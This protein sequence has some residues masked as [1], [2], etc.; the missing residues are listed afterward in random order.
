MNGSIHAEEHNMPQVV[1]KLF[2]DEFC[3]RIGCREATAV[4]SGTSALVGALLSL[5][6]NGGEVITT[7]AASSF[8]KILDSSSE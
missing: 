8:I 5:E 4:N 1:R 7:T 2:E 6:L 3:R